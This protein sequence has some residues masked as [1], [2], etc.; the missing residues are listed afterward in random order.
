MCGITACCGQTNVLPFLLRGLEKLEYRGYDSSGLSLISQ[1]KLITHKKQGRLQVLQETIAPLQLESHCGIAHTRWATHGQP[2]DINAHPH[3]N[4]ANTI[5][6]VHNGIIENAE[7]LKHE[8][9]AEGYHFISDTDSEVIACL[10]DYYN[11]GNP[12]Q[13]LQA[14][15]KRL[16]GSFALAC[17]FL[18]H[19]DHIYVTRWHSPLI[20]AQGQQQTMAASDIPALL[21][22][23]DTFYFLEEGQIACLSLDG[24]QFYDSKLQP[25]QVSPRQVE[26]NEE[27]I[28]KA[29]FDTF[30]EKEIHEQ[31]YAIQQTLANYLHQGQIDLGP[32]P[33]RSEISTIYLIACGT[34]YHA[35]LV[36]SHY[37]EQLT[38]LTCVVKTASEFRYSALHLAIKSLAV[39]V[40]QSGETADTLAACRLAKNQGAFTLAITNVE[41]SSL[42]RLCDHVLFTRAGIEIA[43]AST[44]AYTAQVCLLL[45]LVLSYAPSV[46]EDLLTALA[47]L[48]HLIDSML[49]NESAYQACEHYFSQAHSAFY[50][51]RQLDYVSAMEGALK[52]KEISYIHAEAFAAGELKHG[53]IALVDASTPII[54]LATQQSIIAKTMSNVAETISRQAQVILITSDHQ[55]QPQEH[56]HILYLPQTHP[57]LYPVLTIIPLQILACQLA[58]TRGHDV[59]KPRNLAKSVTVE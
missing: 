22:H 46:H 53:P 24:I 8:M 27:I 40:S 56:L 3:C 15:A 42:A 10:L 19:P 39:F 12:L 28:S 14:V 18:D 38:D 54:A 32:L 25:V 30:M 57:L 11:Q 17:L 31:P 16:E 6:I 41:S 48:P 21:G 4:N 51:G 13:A 45:L 44:K 2:S 5:A 55:M 1:G 43:V 49:Q 58:K 35:C 29:G 52:L 26:R 34:A 7:S 36:A 37:V 9:I 50:I 47:H 23:A 20:L 33:P 59:D